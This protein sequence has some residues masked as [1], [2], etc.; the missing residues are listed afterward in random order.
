MPLEDIARYAFEV[1][2]QAVGMRVRVRVQPVPP[3]LRH[4][5]RLHLPAHCR[6]QQL[7]AQADSKHW[8]AGEH[9]FADQRHFGAQV[10]KR[11]NLVDVHRATEHDEPVVPADIGLR[12]GIAFE[13]D[14]L[15]PA[16]RLPQQ[17]V[18][19]AERFRRNVLENEKLG[20]LVC[21]GA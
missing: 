10:W 6:R 13:V 18:E 20:Q 16:A 3:D 11:T 12:A 2:Q 7:A 15:D 1:P 21:L 8:L 14:V 9:R 17:R 5:V 4:R 19:V